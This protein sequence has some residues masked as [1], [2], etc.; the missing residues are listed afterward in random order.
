MMN[1]LIVDDDVTKVQKLL[2]ALSGIEGFEG[3]RIVH[4]TNVQGAKLRLAE[5]SF[6]LLILDIALPSRL[7]EEV[8]RD[9]GLRLLD[10]ISERDFYKTPN[11]VI[12][13]T[14][15]TDLF[16]DAAS[17]FSQH[18]LTVLQFNPEADDWVLPLQARVRHIIAAKEDLDAN[19][20]DYQSFLAVV[21]AIETPEL[22]S[23]L[24]LG[25]SWRQIHVP[26]DESIY[27]RGEFERE[28]T[29][30]IVHAAAAARIG[31]PAAAAL[32][33]KMIST[34]RPR[35]LAMTGITAG[36]PGKTNFGDIIVADPVWDWG[37]GKWVTK[38]GKLEFLQSPHHLSPTPAIRYKFRQMSN[39][40]A[41]LAD[42]KKGWLGEKPKNELSLLTGP[43]A[44]GA[45]V[46]ADG[47]TSERIKTQHRELLGIE[48]ENY[49]VFAAAEES[50]APRPEVF[51]MKSV[52]DFGDGQKNDTYQNYGAYTSA[53]AL[54]HFVEHYLWP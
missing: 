22:N 54:K 9:A 30:C 25:W 45:S 40:A 53:Q 18:L 47:A 38:D 1:M 42:I 51:S 15:H 52:V 11:H 3:T 28:G 6:D 4:E 24:N 41:A 17:R 37:S 26:H 27:Y 10:E 23:V 14:A 36:I 8:T 2:K 35:Y 12:G 46:L 48:M 44:S 50:K 5:M 43:V 32:T 21:C 13:I 19:F 39:E 34:F 29:N 31:M 7:D 20:E 16:S 33:M 49:A